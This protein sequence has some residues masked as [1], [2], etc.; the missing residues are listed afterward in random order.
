MSDEHADP[1]VAEAASSPDGAEALTPVVP[2][3]DLVDDAAAAAL[4]RARRI[5]RDKGLR[6]GASGSGR[7]RRRPDLDPTYSGSARDG[8]DPG[9]LGD[10]VDRL[11][12]DRGWQVDVSAGAV[13]GRWAHI[14]GPDIAIHVT[15]TTFTDGVLTVRADS[16][17]WAT[18][19]RLMTSALLGRIAAEV[20]EDVVTQVR[21]VGPGAP[22]WSK[23]PR[24]S[25]GPGPRDTYG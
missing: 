9:A 10:T 19:M 14:V 15:P 8:R 20:G 1:T 22:S 2:E 6:P 24:R 17:S 7:T 12:A 4:A 18:Q 11:V 25:T 13:M 3:A 16:T 5:A 23:G 21:V